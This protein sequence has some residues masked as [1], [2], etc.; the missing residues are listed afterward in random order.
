MVES[1]VSTIWRWLN[2][3]LTWGWGVSPPLKKFSGLKRATLTCRGYEPVTSKWWGGPATLRWQRTSLRY[4]A[5]FL[6]VTFV[7]FLFLLV[8]FLLFIFLFFFCYFLDVFYYVSKSGE[9]LYTWQHFIVL[10]WFLVHL[11]KKLLI[12]MDECI[13]Y[14]LCI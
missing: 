14:Q 6:N 7:T 8:F 3:P 1:P 12:V 2:H 9:I 5:T 10:I 4:N 13:M 11:V